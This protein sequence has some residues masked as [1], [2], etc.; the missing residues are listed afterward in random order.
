MAWI[1]NFSKHEGTGR[2]QP[3]NVVGHYK[4]FDLTDGRT[5]IQIDTRGSED[6]DNP[7]KQSQTIKLGREA[8]REL[9][10]ILKEAFNFS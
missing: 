9:F 4:T 8:A 6:R 2:R 1:T 5:I 7:G 3:S 10:G